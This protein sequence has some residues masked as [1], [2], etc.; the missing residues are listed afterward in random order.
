M[1]IYIGNLPPFVEESDLKACF[2]TFGTVKSL[3]LMINRETGRSKGYGF[4]DMPNDEEALRIIKFLNGAI[5]YQQK[6]V[7]NQAK[8]YTPPKRRIQHEYEEQVPLV[9]E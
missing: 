5:F 8:E 7:L 4:C 3:V 2:S 6:L 9:V 1:N